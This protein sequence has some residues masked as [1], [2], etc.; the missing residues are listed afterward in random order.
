MPGRP[1]K[2]RGPG[3]LR[4]VSMFPDSVEEFVALP[5]GRKKSMIQVYHDTGGGQ[6]G[7]TTSPHEVLYTREALLDESVTPVRPFVHLE[8]P[9]LCVGVHFKHAGQKGK[10]GVV[11][12]GIL[13]LK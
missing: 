12:L 8:V 4:D 3:K 6:Q 10:K 9:L 1:K 2:G 13:I 11:E 5:G 7:S